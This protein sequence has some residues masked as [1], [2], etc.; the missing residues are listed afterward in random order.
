MRS[1]EQIVLNEIVLGQIYVASI[2]F[3]A[4]ATK[5]ALRPAEAPAPLAADLSWLLSQAGYALA[6]E[7]TAGLEALGV[8]PR[9]YCVLSTAM[10]GELTQTEIAQAVGLDK[11]TMVVTIDELE[12]KGLAERRPAATDRRARVIAVTKAGE[13]K[14]AQAREVVERINADV[15]EALPAR[16]RKAFVDALRRLVGG[17][18]SKPV[19]CERSVRR[20]TPRG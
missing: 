12:G 15:L 16:E 17:R 1:A 5:E 7:L 14:V 10:T 3:M 6:T 9:G 4:V 20:R 19:Q 11:T 13:R 2:W 8:S 18:L